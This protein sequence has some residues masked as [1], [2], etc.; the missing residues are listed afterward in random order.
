MVKRSI[1]KYA[2]HFELEGKVPAC[3]QGFNPLVETAFMKLSRNRDEV[4][5][6]R[7]QRT[8]AFK[9]ASPNATL[10]K[11]IQASSSW[12]S[13]QRAPRLAKLTAY[14]N[15]EHPEL[16]ARIVEGHCN[17]DYHY[18]DSMLRRPGKGRTGNKLEVYRRSEW[19]ARAG[20]F[21]RPIFEHNAAETYRHNYEVCYW[22]VKYEEEKERQLRGQRKAKGA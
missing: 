10:R 5:C 22:I 13:K 7:C 18:K 1:R 3:V 20:N 16:L 14:I 6:K 17:T 15:E 11:Q 21:V 19:E 12:G 9:D 8:K 2:T 4:D